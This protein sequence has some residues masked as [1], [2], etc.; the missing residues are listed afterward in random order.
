MKQEEVWD[1]IAMPW[2]EFRN[3][4]VSHISEFLKDKS[5]RILDL[6]CGSGRNFS[7]KDN[8]E[9]YGIDFSQKMVDL[10]KERN[11][12]K[13]VKKSEVSSIPYDDEF[14]D[15]VVFNAVLHCV[16]SGEKRKKTLEETYRVLKKNGEAL[17]SVWGR[18]QSRLKNKEKEGFIPW[19]I[20]EEKVQRYTYIYEFEELKSDLEGVGFEIVGSWE[21]GYIGFIVRKPIS[22]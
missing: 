13:E 12:A 20:G 10:S 17:I 15:H 5:G 11:I 8:L 21:D 14:F 6:G 1:A 4:E 16:D 19:T 9:F 3:V 22:S 18:G 2:Q 7:R